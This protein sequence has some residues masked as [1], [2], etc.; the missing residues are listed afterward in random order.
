MRSD[1][2]GPIDFEDAG[3]PGA[4]ADVLT[5]RLKQLGDARVLRAVLEEALAGLSWEPAEIEGHE[6]VYCKIKPGRDINFA[7]AATARWGVSRQLARIHLSGTFWTTLADAQQHFESEAAAF[8]ASPILERPELRAFR[9]LTTLVRSVSAV[10]RVFPVDPV[11]AALVPATD[12]QEL[13]A[14]VA[15]RLPA[16][17]DEGWRP[18]HVDCDVVHYKPGRLCTL[19]YVVR[20]DHPDRPGTREVELFGKAHRDERWQQN[21]DLLETSCRAADASGGTWRAARPVAA[22]PGW[23]LTLQSAVTGRRFSHVF[24]ELTHD[25]ASEGELAEV[26]GHLAAVARAVRSMQLVPA[27]VGPR[28]DFETLLAA[29]DRNLAYL[30]R[31]EPA[32]AA[33]LERLRGDMLRLERETP[34]GA[35]GLAHGDFAHGNVLLGEDGTIGIIDFDRAGQAEPAYD[36]AYFLTHLC[37][38]GIR[39]PRRQAHVERL[40]EVFRSAYLGL[41]PDVSPQRLALYEALDLSAYVLRN[42]RKQSHQAKWIR[43]APDQIAAARERLAVAGGRA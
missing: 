10:I 30:E 15:R 3:V 12:P 22:V 40:C 4:A 19:R 32:L 14:L 13:L 31:S 2:S 17:R 27:R 37:S 18:R 6:V 29:Q 26:G 1:P 28:L 43:W 41:A 39:H 35:L 34:R 33:E 24:T 11:L 16:C 25:L 36:V 21:Y 9:Q 7:V 42:F 20:L 38:Y 8:S 5:A 23:R